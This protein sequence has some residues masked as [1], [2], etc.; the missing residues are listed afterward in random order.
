M[1]LKIDKTTGMPKLEVEE[2]DILGAM[3]IEKTINTDGWKI[4]QGYY[5][6]MRIMIEEQGKNHAEMATGDRKCTV[7]FAKLAGFDLFSSVPNTVINQFKDL[8]KQKDEQEVLQ[9]E[10]R[11]DDEGY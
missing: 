6:S 3:E 5:Q 4:L 7:D 11:N 1:K 2:K 9:N 8:R 10:A